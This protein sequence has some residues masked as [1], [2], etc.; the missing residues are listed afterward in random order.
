VTEENRERADNQQRSQGHL[1][2]ER[3]FLSWL[4]TC[5]ALIALGFVLARFG[6]FLEQFGFIVKNSQGGRL[7]DAQTGHFQSTFLGV[8]VVILGILLLIFALRNYRSTTKAIEK[9]EFSP[10]NFS[11]Y[12]ACISI[13]VLSFAIVIYLLG[14]LI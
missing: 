11:I 4:R 2:N 10:K 14:F 8:C 12:A 3:T 7:V 9:G 1:A 5:I 6:F 13:V